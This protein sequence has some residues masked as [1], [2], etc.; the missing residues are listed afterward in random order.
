V[1]DATGKATQS[2][3]VK[4]KSVLRFFQV[5]MEP[6]RASELLLLNGR[7]VEVRSAI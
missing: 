4:S 3:I 1:G 6:S 2:V 7:R 5:Q